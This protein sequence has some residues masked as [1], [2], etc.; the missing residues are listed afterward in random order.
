MAQQIVETCVWNRDPPRFLIH[1][2]DS[3]FCARFDRR[4]LGLGI[5]QIRT[6]YRSP[7]ANGIADR[8][9]R[10][11]R[12][13]Y[14]DHMLIFNERHLRRVLAEYVVYF[15]HWR[16]HR[17]IGQRAPCSTAHSMPRHDGGKII[18]KPVLGGLHHVYQLAA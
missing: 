18:A 7:Q 1:D 10:S 8:W 16:P 9:V 3:R 12:A 15:N 13:E 2:R 11:A 14:I 5:R 17:S 4:L 6:P